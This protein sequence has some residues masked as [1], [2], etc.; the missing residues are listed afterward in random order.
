MDF[1]AFVSSSRAD[2]ASAQKLYRKIEIYR[3]PR[4]PQ[5]HHIVDENRGR[6]G[7]IFRDREHLPEFCKMGAGWVAG[8]DTAIW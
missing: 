1:R 6:L 3:L 2:A 8:A 5:P 4:D 7:R